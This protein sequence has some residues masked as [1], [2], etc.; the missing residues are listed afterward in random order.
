MAMRLYVLDA[1]KNTRLENHGLSM[2]ILKTQLFLLLYWFGLD[3][4][5]RI[6]NREIIV[7]AL[8]TRVDLLKKEAL[9]LA[10]LATVSLLMEKFNFSVIALTLWQG[11][12]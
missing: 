11:K 3:V 5:L 2:V 6:T 1:A 12:Q 10:R 4:I 8:T 9:S 7:G